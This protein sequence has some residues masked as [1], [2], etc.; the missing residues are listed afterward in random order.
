MNKIH[1]VALTEEQLGVLERLAGD[2]NPDPSTAMRARCLIRLDGSRF[3]DERIARALS[4]TW[5][6]VWRLRRDFA[7]L[8]LEAALFGRPRQSSGAPAIEGANLERLLAVAAETNDSGRPL[9]LRA[10]S[11]RLRDEAGLVVSHETVRLTLRRAG[12]PARSRRKPFPSKAPGASPAVPAAVWARLG[13]MPAG[14]DKW[15]TRA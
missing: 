5:H 11:R 8:G 10:L 6:Q 1:H 12:A 9:S 14:L 3:S 2:G 4:L 15:A 13:P 7:T